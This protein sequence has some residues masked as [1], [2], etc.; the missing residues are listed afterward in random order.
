MASRF[1][2]GNREL[3]VFILDDEP[4]E[5]IGPKVAT[6]FFFFFK[7][8]LVSAAFVLHVIK[9]EVFPQSA[10]MQAARHL[11]PFIHLIF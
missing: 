10:L 7:R 5:M 2:P 1:L 4:L 6:G 9:S 11:L 8:P 3:I